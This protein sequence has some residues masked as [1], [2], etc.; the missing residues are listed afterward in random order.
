LYVAVSE[1][2]HYICMSQLPDET[3]VM[4]EILVGSVTALLVSF[5][6]SS[7]TITTSKQSF[8][9]TVAALTVTS[10]AVA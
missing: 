1:L 10:I 9:H 8:D 2:L 4:S 7:S 6:I 5:H 3:Q